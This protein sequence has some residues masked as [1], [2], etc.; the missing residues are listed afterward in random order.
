MK[1]PEQYIKYG[2]FLL[3]SRQHSDIFYDANAMLTNTLYLTYF[4]QNIPWANHY[5]GIATFGE[6]IVTGLKMENP[7]REISVIKDGELKGRKPEGPWI[8]IDDVVTTGRSL[9]EAIALIG[10]QPSQIIV[11]V[12]RRERNENPKVRAIFEL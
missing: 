9:L 12:D 4:V 5:V 8:L 11:V 1:F 10:S 7:S 3:H 6:A 2:D